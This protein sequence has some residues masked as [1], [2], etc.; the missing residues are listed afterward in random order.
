VA[1]ERA[2]HADLRPGDR[3]PNLRL[4]LGD[5]RGPVNLFDVIG[6]TL[7]HLVVFHP[8]TADAGQDAVRHVLMQLV[9]RYA[10]TVAVH[11]IPAG[12]RR[13]QCRHVAD[14]CLW[15]VRPDG[16]IAYAGSLAHLDRLAAYMDGLYVHTE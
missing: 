3:V 15:L 1:G 13:T 7:H 4:D 12:G 11:V 16:H 10:I 6:D 8:P 5:G 9:D 2:C 14:P